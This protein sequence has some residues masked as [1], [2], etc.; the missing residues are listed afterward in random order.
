VFV[1]CVSDKDYIPPAEIRVRMKSKEFLVLL[2]LISML[3]NAATYTVSAKGVQ[4]Q[5]AVASM[6]VTSTVL[7]GI[8]VKNN[9][10]L[11][12][13]NGRYLMNDSVTVR[14][15]GTLVVRNA[16]L[17]FDTT[18]S[19]VLYTYDNATVIM[20]NTTISDAEGYYYAYIRGKTSLT[21]NA[22]SFVG[23]SY[24][25]FYDT[26]ASSI[27]NSKAYRSAPAT[28][29]Q[30]QSRIRSPNISTVTDCQRLE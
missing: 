11:V 6:K 8:E 29:R 4:P 16:V 26:S 14:D 30:S 20:F 5:S 3:S 15:N 19:T 24:F 18:D 7:A 28:T 17:D 22:S 25:Y 13:E 27:A 10:T 12:I 23:S 1:V 2:M 21:V 9:E